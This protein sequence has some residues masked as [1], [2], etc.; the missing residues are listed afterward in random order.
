MNRQLIDEILAFIKNCD[1]DFFHNIFM[2]EKQAKA[3]KY[4]MLLENLEE[5]NVSGMIKALK[6]KLSFIINR[7]DAYNYHTNREEIVLNLVSLNVADYI[8]SLIKEKHIIDPL[9]II[10]YAYIE[11]SK[12]LYYDI[13]YVKK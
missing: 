3:L 10:R 1:E 12:V 8:V 2:P 13:S 7:I 4:L 9:L 11:L 6:E 5:K